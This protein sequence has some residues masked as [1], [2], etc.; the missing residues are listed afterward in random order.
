VDGDRD[1]LVPIPWQTVF[2]PYDAHDDDDESALIADADQA[3][4]VRKGRQT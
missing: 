2:P 3:A 4:E 1:Y